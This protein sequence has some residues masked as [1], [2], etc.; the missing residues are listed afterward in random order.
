MKIRTSLALKYTLVTATVFL[1]CMFTVYYLSERIRSNT[2]FHTLKGEAV[3]KAHLFLSHMVDARTMQ[4]IYWN[5]Q[6]FIHEVEVAVYTPDFHLV[7][8]DAADVDRI[9]ET[10]AMIR[11]ICRKGNWE[12]N[13][14]AYQAV[15]LTYVYQGKTYVVTAAAYD[16][17]GYQN[18]HELR[19]ILLILC[20]LGLTVLFATGFL[21]AYIALKPI[22]LLVRETEQI[23]ASQISRRI[24]LRSQDEIGELVC[25]FNDLLSRLEVS[26]NAQKEFVGHASHEL[27]TPLAALT[28]EL[29]LALQKDRTPE[30]YRQALENALGDARKMNRL[31][32]GLLDLAKADYG[33]DQIRM[34][35]IRF[36]EL[37]M[38][39]RTLVLRAHPDYRVE[40]FFTQEPEDEKDLLVLGNVYL[41]RVA[42]TNLMEN[43][44]KYSAD[45]T[46]FIQISFW[47]KR[48]ILRFSDNGIGMSAEDLNHVFTLFY[49]G[50]DHK[51]YEGHGIGMT[52]VHKIVALHQ[53]KISIFSESGK[54]TTF[55]LELTHM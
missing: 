18:L 6:S 22:R 9:K 16:G 51:N 34:E 37:L 35:E 21:L 36:D 32:A 33:A 27:R 43:N 5:N 7:Y 4:S 24:P 19:I 50:P 54:G 39:V 55:I 49:R 14:G 42:L 40:L 44:C 15:G 8:H 26:F 48:L 31:I 12:W 46:S 47:E 10:P 17:Y 1:A 25:T 20:V 30:Q 38:E 45:H 53:G 13:I 41:L 52:L 3:T 29:D 28:A 2:F 23:T 11:D